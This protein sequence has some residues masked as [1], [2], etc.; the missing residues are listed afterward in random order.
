M[1]MDEKVIWEF[2]DTHREW[3]APWRIQ[4]CNSN[5]CSYHD[6]KIGDYWA[7][8]H[9]FLKNI[10]I[11]DFS[12]FTKFFKSI[13]TSK[14]FTS[15]FPNFYRMVIDEDYFPENLLKDITP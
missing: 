15:A 7:I 13:Y 14:P 5:G 9:I 3:I 1:N 6:L 4:G 2:P 8:I 12:K 11:T 10:K